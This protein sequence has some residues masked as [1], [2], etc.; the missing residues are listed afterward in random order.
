MI[1]SLSGTQSVGKT[2][3]VNI[4]KQMSDFIIIDEIVRSI[5]KEFGVNINENGNI[6]T[7]L[8]VL[9]TH[10][11]NLLKHKNDLMITDRSLLDAVAYTIYLHHKC[12]V[13]IWVKNYA[14]DLFRTYIRYYNHI[15]YIPAEFA[16]VTDNE[17]SISE[18]FRTDVDKI[19]MDLL[20][21]IEKEN[22]GN[23]IVILTGSVFNR[24][25]KFCSSIGMKS[26][27]KKV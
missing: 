10:I 3:I 22:Y 9:N 23:N 19:F 4:V 25:N 6:D 11:F 5:K 12:E 14:L 7:Q 21:T 16:I 1:V 20:G 24:V 27:L 13:P 8:L 26:Q 15:F 17:R 2:T 18:T